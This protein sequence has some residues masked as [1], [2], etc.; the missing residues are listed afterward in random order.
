M[1]QKLINII[2]YPFKLFWRITGYRLFQLFAS[3]I[4]VIEV[5]VTIYK[6][7]YSDHV[8]QN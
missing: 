3:I 8:Y 1:T 2:T 5:A 4:F 6:H 7:E